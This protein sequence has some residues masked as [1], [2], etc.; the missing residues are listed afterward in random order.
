M[1]Q[2]KLPASFWR[3]D[4]GM[5]SSRTMVTN[6]LHYSTPTQY[7]GLDV[8]H[9]AQL[10]NNYKTNPAIGQF[11]SNYTTNTTI[12]QLQVP[13]QYRYSETPFAGYQAPISSRL[14][15]YSKLPM[16]VMSAPGV[17][18]THAQIDA[19][20]R[21]SIPDTTAVYYNRGPTTGHGFNPRYNSLLIQPEVMLQLPLVHGQQ[22]E[23]SA[24]KG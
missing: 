13:S 21:C 1:R 7:T 14:I 17:K 11:Q 24:K 5:M 23:T 6:D 19:R 16:S 2:R 22:R 20:P 3:Q 12:G 9:N 18:I 8:Q 4:L 15:S 10:Y